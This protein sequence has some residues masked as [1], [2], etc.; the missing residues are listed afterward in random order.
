VDGFLYDTP[1]L[2]Q[3]RAV[4]TADVASDLERVGQF[5]KRQWHFE[6]YSCLVVE[7]ESGCLAAT[8][9]ILIGTLSLMIFLGVR[10]NVLASIAHRLQGPPRAFVPDVVAKI[11][12]SGKP[13]VSIDSRCD[14][15]VWL[16]S[17]TYDGA[18][19]IPGKCDLMPLSI[20][21]LHDGV[22]DIKAGQKTTLR[23]KILNQGSR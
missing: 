7:G 12:N 21:L 6:K 8:V 3:R 16:P 11:G 19:R 9:V 17:A 5:I 14:F 18:P 2:P 20:Q 15:V 1:I 22:I 23:V 13:D 10:L 4:S